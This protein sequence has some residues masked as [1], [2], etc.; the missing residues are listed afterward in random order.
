MVD[1]RD[2]KALRTSIARLGAVP[3]Q[4]SPE[5]VLE[6]LSH[7]VPVVAGLIQVVNLDTPGMMSGHAVRLPL[8]LL[9]G[10]MATP[11]AHLRR[12]VTPVLRAKDG[13]FWASDSLATSVRERISVLD[14]LEKYGLGQGAGFKLWSRPAASRGTEHV[15]LALI[16]ERKMKF[17]PRAGTLLKELTPAIQDAVDRISLPLVA[18]QSLVS[19]M[20]DDD[21]HGF[22]VVSKSGSLCELNRRAYNLVQLY[23]QVAKVAKSR[24]SVAD[25]AALALSALGRSTKAWHVSRGSA[26]LHVRRHVLHARPH[27]LPE[28]MTLLMLEERAVAGLGPRFSE[29]PGIKLTRRKLEIAEL[30]VSTGL[31]YQG[32]AKRLSISDGT[33]RTTVHAIYKEYDVNSRDELVELYWPKRGRDEEE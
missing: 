28:D 9:Q 29:L 26:I 13:D 23:R 30:L 2:A 17:S 22:I 33:V 16:T 4:G 5:Q 11:R 21:E 24:R 32:I 10:W 25:F 20:M 18:S 8:E 7:S 14:E 6:A 15:S 1:S 19:Q 12:A 3:L 31:S 27:N